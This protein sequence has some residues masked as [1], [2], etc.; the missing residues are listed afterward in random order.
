MLHH[1]LSKNASQNLSSYI[2]GRRKL[3]ERA[4]EKREKA[5]ETFNTLTQGGGSCWDLQTLRQQG[6]RVIR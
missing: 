4:R 2:E 3:L 5:N 1:Y 6:I